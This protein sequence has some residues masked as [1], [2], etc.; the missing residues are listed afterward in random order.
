MYATVQ[1]KWRYWQR[2]VEVIVQAS[3]GGQDVFFIYKILCMRAY[4]SEIWQRESP[5]KDHIQ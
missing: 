4:P 2:V 5:Q 3:G 1:V